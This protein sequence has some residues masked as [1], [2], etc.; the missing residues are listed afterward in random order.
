MRLSMDNLFA[1]GEK[2]GTQTYVD[3][4]GGVVVSM[5]P[6]IQF[7]MQKGLRS[8][9]S[10]AGLQFDG[11]QVIPEA[12]TNTVTPAKSMPAPDLCVS[13]LDSNHHGDI[14]CVKDKIDSSSEIYD[15]HL[16]QKERLMEQLSMQVKQFVWQC[17]YKFIYF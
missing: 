16:K 17:A 9:L 5:S 11:N 13:N 4:G 8:G 1:E 6:C 14:L 2:V 10:E 15:E 12:W 3:E 7:Q